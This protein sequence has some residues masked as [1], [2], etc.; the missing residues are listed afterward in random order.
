MGNCG[1]R[2][3]NAV[4]PVHAQGNSFPS[5]CSAFDSADFFGSLGDRSVSDCRDPVGR[6]GIFFLV[7]Y[8]FWFP[9]ISRWVGFGAESPKYDLCLS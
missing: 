5:S 9:G 6:T 1:T 2:E 8:H 3:E 4:V 7:D